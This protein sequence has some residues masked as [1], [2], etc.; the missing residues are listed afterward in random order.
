MIDSTDSNHAPMRLDF[1]L[2]KR[3]NFHEAK[4]GEYGGW[5]RT[6]VLFLTRNCHKDT[7][8]QASE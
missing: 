6:V 1:N 2:G 8:V 4:L 7:A 5:S 3:K